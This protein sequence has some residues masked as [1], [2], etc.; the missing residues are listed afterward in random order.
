[1]RWLRDREVRRWELTHDLKDRE[2]ASRRLVYSEYL[3]ALARVRNGLREVAHAPSM[4]RDD[5]ALRLRDVFLESG[6]YELRF[7][8]QLASPAELIDCSERAY[9]SLRRLRLRVEE[10]ASFQDDAYLMARDDYHH[11]LAAL[12]SSMRIDLG[13]DPAGRG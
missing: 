10:G 12:R 4:G 5:R 8:I 6:A 13:V 2:R 3:A 7:Q 11:S 1:M 9:K